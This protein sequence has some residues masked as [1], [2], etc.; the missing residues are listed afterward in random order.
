MTGSGTHTWSLLK[1][2]PWIWRSYGPKSHVLIHEIETGK[3]MPKSGKQYLGIGKR[4]LGFPN[5]KRGQP[6]PQ[7]LT[8]ITIAATHV[9]QLGYYIQTPTKPSAS[10]VFQPW[11][12]KPSRELESLKENPEHVEPPLPCELSIAY[13][14]LLKTILYSQT[15][16]T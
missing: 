16:S 8:L 1:R 9:A 11:W 4:L 6:V 7:H 13:F 3:Q 14:C 10:V 5:F 12:I 15:R 2:H